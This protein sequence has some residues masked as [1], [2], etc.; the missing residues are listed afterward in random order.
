[1]YAIIVSMCHAL[2]GHALICFCTVIKIFTDIV[3]YSHHISK[4]DCLNEARS[5]YLIVP[6]LSF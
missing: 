3:V 2:L 6:M 5:L 4:N 1:M